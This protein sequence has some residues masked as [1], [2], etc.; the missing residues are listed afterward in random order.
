MVCDPL[1]MSPVENTLQRNEGIPQP[2][3][4]GT[5]NFAGQ[6][7][8]RNSKSELRILN[9]EILRILREISRISD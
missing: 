3:E 8:S 5:K 1:T 6:S 4:A 7:E 9:L 2:G